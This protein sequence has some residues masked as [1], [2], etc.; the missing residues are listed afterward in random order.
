M[1]ASYFKIEIW[2]RMLFIC[3]KRVLLCWSHT[4]HFRPQTTAHWRFYIR[5]NTYT[6]IRVSATA[7]RSFFALAHNEAKVAKKKTHS[8]MYGWVYAS[9]KVHVCNCVFVI[10]LRFVNS[11]SLRISVALCVRARNVLIAVA[12]ARIYCRTSN[13]LNFYSENK[14]HGKVETKEEWNKINMWNE[15]NAWSSSE[16]I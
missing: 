16:N 10:S 13:T 9:Q 5:K 12:I 4:F 6:Y 1:F 2:M 15:K 14:I 3:I 11:L 7:M 8:R